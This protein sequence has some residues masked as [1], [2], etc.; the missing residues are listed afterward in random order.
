MTRATQ[1]A[2]D[3]GAVGVTRRPQTPK[4]RRAHDV[5]VAEEV[6]ASE[7]RASRVAFCPRCNRIASGQRCG[8]CKQRLGSSV[9]AGS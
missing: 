3:F 2:L 7:R 6:V 9:E 5:A 1:G 8:W 4:G